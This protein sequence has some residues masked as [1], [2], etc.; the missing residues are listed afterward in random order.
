MGLERG[1]RRPYVAIIEAAYDHDPDLGRW[2]RGLAA[3]AHRCFGTRLGAIAYTFE[4]RADGDLA[5]SGFEAGGPAD[6]A[7]AARLL[8]VVCAP[9]NVALRR[10]IY[11]ATP[12]AELASEAAS[13]LPASG[14]VAASLQ[15]EGIVDVLGIRAVDG[16]GRGCVVAVLL[17]ELTTLPPRV[18]ASCNR[19]AAHLLAAWRL[20]AQASTTGAGVALTLDDDWLFAVPFGAT[21]ADP[22]QASALWEGLMTGQWEV[23][24]SRDHLEQRTLLLRRRRSEG[25]DFVGLSARERAVAALAV[26]GHSLKYIASELGLSAPTVTEHMKRALAKLGLDTR[27]ELVRLNALLRPPGLT[28]APP[29]ASPPRHS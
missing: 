12:V 7:K 11:A 6:P 13:D 20:R 5:C 26:E 24:A 27:M 14:D 25:A 1:V 2:L 4:L 3:A 15:R 29:G 18:R 9:E 28:L 17:D 21:R 16:E 23:I 8:D 19:V 22:F 10:R